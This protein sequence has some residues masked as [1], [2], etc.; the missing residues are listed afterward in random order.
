M[1]VPAGGAATGLPGL[2]E[3]WQWQERVVERGA[4]L[5][6]LAGPGRQPDSQPPGYMGQQVHGPGTGHQGLAWSSSRAHS[7]L[8]VA[9]QGRVRHAQSG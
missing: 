8:A 3:V 6:A 1:S 7:A 9:S 5:V 2:P 4:A